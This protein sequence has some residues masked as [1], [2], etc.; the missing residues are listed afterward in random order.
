MG[1]GFTDGETLPSLSKSPVINPE[2]SWS[3]IKKGTLL[4]A[5]IKCILGFKE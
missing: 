5:I 3:V 1:T 2:I 4:N